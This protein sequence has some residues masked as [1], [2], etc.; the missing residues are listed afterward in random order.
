MLDSATG[1]SLHPANL[2]NSISEGALQD[3]TRGLESIEAARRLNGALEPVDNSLKESD[4]EQEPTEIALDPWTAFTRKWGYLPPLDDDLSKILAE[5][6]ENPNLAKSMVRISA[7]SPEFEESLEARNVPVLLSEDVDSYADKIK[8]LKFNK[9]HEP[10]SEKNCHDL[11]WKLDQAKCHVTSSEALFQRT[12]MV[13]LIAR[14]FLIYQRDPSKPQI[15][16]FSVEEPW[17]CPPMPTR[18]VAGLTDPTKAEHKF[19]SQPKPDLALCFNREA[20][21]PEKLWRVLPRATRALACAENTHSSRMMVFHFLSIEAKAAAFRL[22]DTKARNQSLNNAS[23]ALFNMFAFFRDAGS[24]YE[25][26]FYEKVRFF[27]V[28]AVR[29]GMLVRVHRAIKI[30]DDELSNRLVIPEEDS[31]R[32]DFEYREYARITGIENYTRAKVFKILKPIMQYAGN[33][34]R[35]WLQSAA[36]DLAKK[37]DKDHEGFRARQLLGFYRYGQPSPKTTVNS[38]QTSA[39]PSRNGGQGS[40]NGTLESTHRGTNYARSGG[41][42]K[43]KNSTAQRFRLSQNAGAAPENPRKRGPNEMDVDED[44][45]NACTQ[46]SSGSKRYKAAS[47]EHIS[48]QVMQQLSQ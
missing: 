36:H 31:Y 18:A 13:H 29:E 32:L 42:N 39:A 43:N 21:I 35:V 44:S 16:N 33:E 40:I 28:V 8:L 12:L 11:L 14:H 45:A 37:L 5:I 4:S 1:E 10:I 19:L 41:S 6:V 47:Q 20:I 48:S 22:D 3:L 17:A 25:K 2:S 15:F 7:D 46:E 38:K 26:L 9:W 24:K 34:L 30:P 27:S 23:Q